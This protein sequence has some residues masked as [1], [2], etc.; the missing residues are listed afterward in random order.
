MTT[1]TTT[2]DSAPANR[3]R[4]FAAHRLSALPVLGTGMLVIFT[5]TRLALSIYARANVDFS[6]GPL[7][8]TFLLGLL[9]DLVTI[10]CVCV[11]GA[12]YLALIP[13]RLFH[14]RW[15]RWFLAAVG[16]ALFWGTFF[17]AAAEW[18]FWEEFSSR[19][20][21][22]AVDYLIYTHEVIGNIVE[23]YPMPLILSAISVASAFLLWLVV[24]IGWYAR[25]T[26]GITPIRS[27]WRWAAVPV[28]LS[29][30]AVLLVHQDAVSILRNRYNRELAGNGPYWFVAAF[31]ANSLDYNHFYPTMP[32]K[33]AFARLRG[34][35]EEP[36]ATFVS[37]QPFDIT[38]H[39]SHK[40][41][42]HRWNV[43]LITV[44]S[45]SG[46]YL[47]VFGDRHQITPNLDKLSTRSIFFTRLMA[48]GTRTVRG[49]EALT[50][51]LPPTPGRSIIKRP[52]NENMFSTGQL[53]RQRGYDVHFIYG[54]HGYF[55]NMNYFFSKNGFAITDQGSKH[56][57]PIRFSNIW[58]ACD[59]D[60]FSW[61][62][63][64]ADQAWKAGKPFYHFVMT[65][66]NHRP[67]TFP[68][69]VIDAPQKHRSSAVKYTDFAI[70]EFLENAA[71]KPWFHNTVFVIIADHCASSAGRNELNV[72]KYHIPLYI[73]APELLPPRQVDTLCGQ[74][75]VA[76][77]LLGLLNWTYDSRFYGHDVLAENTLRPGRAFIS[78]YHALGY[79]R[80]NI[81]TV[82]EPGRKVR[83]FACDPA[84]FSITPT[85]KSDTFLR[86]AIASYQ[87]AYYLFSQHQKKAPAAIPGEEKEHEILQTHPLDI[88]G[89]GR[90][91]GPVRTKLP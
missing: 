39:I 70:A 33:E 3:W 6:P 69:G 36:N 26:A 17:N 84:D 59:Q 12:L 42:E 76:P 14:R 47:G 52:G 23:S 89:T 30:A 81:L 51:S 46:R 60:L 63:D 9:F 22:I 38:R 58:G 67:Y 32:L 78:N 7:V 18:F 44:E 1:P 68:E 45:L 71:R 19:F 49:M 66:S 53:F 80:D 83:T 74:I 5:L 25:W 48:S 56:K 61:V 88:T 15:H 87:T 43:I 55:D 21:F 37:D 90:H 86:D 85:K 10:A 2:A 75:D 77:T 41:E 20:N 91:A 8:L 62:I 54:G 35:L 64:A 82:L 27:R 50:L 73:Y 72:K 31:Q 11:P 29:A 40:G 57:K 16:F 4:R 13:E 34:L 28:L 65:T 79:L 24:K